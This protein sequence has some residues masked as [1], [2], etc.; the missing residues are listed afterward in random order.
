MKT[1]IVA[2]IT[3]EGIECNSPNF[4]VGGNNSTKVIT[5]TCLQLQ[6][7]YLS[8]ALDTV[9]SKEQPQG[10]SVIPTVKKRKLKGDAW[11]EFY[12]HGNHVKV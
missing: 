3:H 6:G 9:V 10:N 4:V 12:P 11:S 2:R 1:E 8:L 5:L 7:Y